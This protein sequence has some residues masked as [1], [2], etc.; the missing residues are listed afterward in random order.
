M[1]T[2]VI[3]TQKE[4]YKLPDKFDEFTYIEIRSEKRIIVNKALGNS[5]VEALGNSSVEALGNSSVEARENSSV[6]AR[7]NSSVVAC[8]NS[9]VVARGNSSVV[10]WENSS[11]V[12][13]GN[14]S[15]VACGNSSV[16]ALGNSSVVA[17]ENSSV[18][19]RGNSSVVAC[20]NSSVEAWGN[21]ATWC[22][23]EYVSILLFSFAICFEIT[24][25]KIEK[26]SKTATIIKP[27][28]KKGL[29]G[30]L[31]N[32]V[33]KDTQKIILYKKVSKNFKTQENND[34]KTLWKIGSVVEHKNWSPKDNEC[35]EGKFHACS[36]TYFCNEF[37]NEKDDK[38]IA[39]EVDKKD[40]Y[41][42]PKPNYLY[43]I[44][45]KKCKVL[46]QCDKLGIEIKSP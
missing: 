15:V 3:K 40:L 33:I 21:V 44:A 36:R 24:K 13:R 20:G 23:S 39:I 5:S 11:V 35:G 42:W 12:A 32:N 27:I 29:S 41:A 4:F 38:Y 28:I 26:K 45:F 43:K 8:G 14:S 1:K 7:G 6:E 9:S 37:R 10:A 30:W 2:I 18:V 19:A 46:Y 25:G 34:N 31:E 16:E 17:W 22:Q